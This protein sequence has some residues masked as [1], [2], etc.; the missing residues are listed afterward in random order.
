MVDTSVLFLLLLFFNLNTIQ[1]I[2]SI[3]ST[4]GLNSELLLNTTS[5][6]FKGK[7]T[8]IQDVPIKQYLGIPY[9]E[10]PLRFQIPILRR[11]NNKAILQAVR[12]TPA[13]LQAPSSLSY[14]P[15][16]LT[17][18]YDEDC[19]ALNIFIPKTK[20]ST[21]KAIMVFCHGGSNQVGSGSLFDGSAIAAIGDVIIITINYRLNILGFLTPDS[22]IMSGNYGLHDQLLAL[23]WISMNA[24]YFNGDP[25]RITYV[26]HSAGAANAILLA[27]SERSNGMIAR[28]IAQSGGPLNQWA[29]DRN[30][31]V[32]FDN[33]IQR[34]GMNP[35]QKLSQSNIERLKNLTAKEFRYMYHSG[36]EISP[37]Y[38]YPVIDD[39]ILTDNLEDLIRTG[40]LTNVDILIGAT[41]DESLYFA[42]DHIFHHYLPK[43][44]RTMA[45]LILNS[46]TSTTNNNQTHSSKSSDTEPA[47]YEEPLGFSYFKKNPYIKNYLK[48]NYPNLLCY[49][50][51]IQAR[52]MPAAMYQNNVTVVAHL[53]TNLVSDLMFYYDLVRF[54]HERLH[55]TTSASTY[56]YYYSYPPIYDFEHVVRRMPHKVGHFAELDLIWG[57]PFFNRSNR[58]N[59]NMPFNMHLSYTPEEI[60]LSYQM[61]RYWTNFA[62]SGNPNDPSAVSTLWPRY[63]QTKKSFI[64]FHANKLNIEDNFLEERFQFWNMLSHRPVCNPFRWYQTCLLVGILILAILLITI[65]I[66][67]NTKRSRRNIK[68]TEL[69]TT[70]IL[71]TYRFL[72]S[73]V[74]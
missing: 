68:P 51:E 1:S 65:Y 38:P 62:K 20:S 43:K 13:C 64:N 3:N 17:D 74:S 39:D 46:R 44:Y 61:I 53:Y 63:E 45:Y 30:P 33:V 35:K 2:H 4:N 54:L 23:K 25:K 72:P 18:M 73:V 50:D 57:M 58:T 69:T 21:P 7:L 12:R 19:L 71:T 42:E 66:F 52:Y 59:L 56:V 16:E 9:G 37:T 28:V 15:F 67:H 5:G 8:K 34:N 26:G 29:I 6:L 27:M 36:L 41:D 32:R 55:S 11:Y 10:K 14:G 24:K 60:Q 31:R 70:N 40:P 22:K 47:E 49:Y 48:S